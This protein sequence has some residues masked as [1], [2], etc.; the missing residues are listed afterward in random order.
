MIKI[1][2]FNTQHISCEY[3][4]SV[5]K[6]ERHFKMG[7]RYLSYILNERNF[8]DDIVLC[9][10]S[11]LIKVIESFN[12][13]FPDI[14]YDAEDWRYFR[15]YMIRQYERVRKGILHLVLNSLNLSVCP[16]CNRQ[17]IFGTDNNRKVG[18]QFDHFIVK[19][20]IHI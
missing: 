16:Y 2:D 12:L 9:P 6:M 18:A 14:D 17:Y 20:N 4:D 13:R 5:I 10:P 3:A 7:N 15:N 11:K 1:N 19:V 8:R